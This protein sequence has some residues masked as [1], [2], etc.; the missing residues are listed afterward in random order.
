M[1]ATKKDRFE[2]AN[3]HDYGYQRRN[4]SAGYIGG[5][6]YPL[7]ADRERERER[8]RNNGQRRPVYSTRIEHLELK[9]DAAGVKRFPL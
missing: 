7:P 1:A 9:L 3:L 2:A 6:C 5:I 4:M 8:D